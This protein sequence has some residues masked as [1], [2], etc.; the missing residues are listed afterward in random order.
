[1]HLLLLFIFISTAAHAQVDGDFDFGKISAK[2]FKL[3]TCEKDSSANAVFLKEFGKSRMDI[4]EKSLIIFYHHVRLKIF[5]KNGFHYADVK[6]NLRKSGH[7]SETFQDLCA[8]TFNFSDGIVKEVKVDPKTLIE[9]NTS[10]YRM[11]MKFAMPD[12]TQC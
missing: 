2:E 9:E 8:S 11:Q 6:I 1:M 5:N 12:I 10:D 3:K 7:E 4:Y